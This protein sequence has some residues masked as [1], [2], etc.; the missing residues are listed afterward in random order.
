MPAD[1]F[2][3]TATDYNTTGLS[4]QRHP[5]VRLRHLKQLRPCTLANQLSSLSNG[6]FVR[7]SGLV[8]SKIRPSSASGIIFLTLEDETGNI[9]VIVWKA[10]QQNFRQQLINAKL[11]VIYGTSEQ[12]DGATHVIAGRIIDYSHLLSNT[13]LECRDFH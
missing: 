5:I 8:I 6:R 9:N 12:K 11:V 4:L 2:T 1:E 10:T 13:Q 7:V 3:N